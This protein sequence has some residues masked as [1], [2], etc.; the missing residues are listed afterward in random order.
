MHRNCFGHAQGFAPL[1]DLRT[2]DQDGPYNISL[3]A[4]QIA[5]IQGMLCGCRRSCCLPCL[6]LVVPAA[7]TLSEFKM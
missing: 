6:R 1:G 2:T 4:T 7:G 3:L 5:E